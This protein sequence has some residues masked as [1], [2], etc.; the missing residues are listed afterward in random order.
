M[1]SRTK[2]YNI[3]QSCIKSAYFLYFFNK[4]GAIY[5]F[6]YFFSVS[7]SL[8]LLLLVTNLTPKN[9]STTAMA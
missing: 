6:C 3:P 1:F 9:T 8:R 4:K 7:I 5:V 2:V